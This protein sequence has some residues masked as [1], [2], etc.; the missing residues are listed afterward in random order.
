MTCQVAA[1]RFAGSANKVV[2]PGITNN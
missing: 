2:G 1:C